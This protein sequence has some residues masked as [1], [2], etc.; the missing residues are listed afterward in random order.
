MA[1]EQRYEAWHQPVARKRRR[2][3]DPDPP[4]DP[5]RGA[6]CE[7]L[8]PVHCLFDQACAIQQPLPVLGECISARQAIEELQSERFFQRGDAPGDGGM[9][10]IELPRGLG[11][12]AGPRQ[13]D[14]EAEVVPVQHRHICAKI[15]R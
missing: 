7:A 8:H 13:L 1:S 9:V 3:A 12:A 2:R 14:K 5:R 6:G 15:P 10:G 4:D 11:Q